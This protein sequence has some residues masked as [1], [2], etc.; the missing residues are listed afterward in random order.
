VCVEP[1]QGH[2][3]PGRGARWRIACEAAEA[4]ESIRL[5]PA[6][7]ALPLPEPEAP[8]CAN[9]RHL[10]AARRAGAGRLRFERVDGASALVGAE[11]TSP[12]QIL[13]PRARGRSAWA[14]LASHGGGL[15]SGDD[16]ALDVGVGAGAVALVA[17]QAE[18]KVYRAAGAGGAVSALT[19][20]IAA[21]GVLAVLPEPVSPFAGA[22]HDARARFDLDEGASAAAVDAVVAG[23]TA[24]GERWAFARHASRTEVRIGGRLVLSDAL[25]L[26]PEHGGP[27]P[28]RLG[29][30]DALALAFAV[31]PAFEAGARALVE[32]LAAAAVEPGAAALLAAS[33][34]PGGALVRCA[35]TSAEALARALRGALAFVAAPLGDDPF[36]RRY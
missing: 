5:K 25:V 9:L 14:V 32:R 6:M 24:R 28:A 1:P 8:R 18:T 19:A 22:L 3:R 10:A 34:L 20:R 11:A 30:F 31:G 4:T 15:V 36:V 2:A 7:S 12:L 17:T 23:R 27:L 16:V 35:A 13:S 26:D 33:P 21:G 29:R